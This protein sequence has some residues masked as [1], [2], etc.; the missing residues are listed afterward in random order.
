MPGAALRFIA[1]LCRSEAAAGDLTS[2]AGIRRHRLAPRC[3]L[4][5][6][7][8]LRPRAAAAASHAASR[9]RPGT[10]PSGSA[11]GS[12]PPPPRLGRPARSGPLCSRLFFLPPLSLPPHFSPSFFPSPPLSCILSFQKQTQGAPS[13]RRVSPS[14]RT[15]SLPGG[16]GRGYCSPLLLLFL[17][18]SSSSSSFPQ[19]GEHGCNAQAACHR[20]KP[21][22]LLS[23]PSGFAGARSAPACGL[24]GLSAPGGGGARRRRRESPAASGLGS[25]CPRVSPTRAPGASRTDL[26]GQCCCVLS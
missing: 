19:D 5:G 7:R 17:P 24:H 6:P 2:S 15:L 9:Q 14:S 4:P 3:A 26:V 20:P 22:R 10:C 1:R 16:G 12:A 11:L 18:R 13:G 23:M 21:A 25:L 8:A